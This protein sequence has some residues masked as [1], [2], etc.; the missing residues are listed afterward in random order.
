MSNQQPIPSVDRVR[1]EA[2]E[3]LVRQDFDG[4][5]AL[6]DEGLQRTLGALLGYGSGVTSPATVDVSGVTTSAP[7][8]L[9]LGTLQYYIS[10]PTWQDASDRKSVV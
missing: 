10:V 5:L 9:R 2:Q 4:T 1:T 3:V 6:A 7:Q 8:I